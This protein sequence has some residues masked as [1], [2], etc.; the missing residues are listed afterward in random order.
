MTFKQLIDNRVKELRSK[1]AITLSPFWGEL[2]TQVK[3][4]YKSVGAALFVYNKALLDGV[5][6]TAVA[7]LLDIQAFEVYGMGGIVCLKST[8]DYA[9]SLGIIVIALTDKT[10]VTQS[11][12][13]AAARAWIAPIDPN[14]PEDSPLREGAFDCDAM[15][16]NPVALSGKNAGYVAVETERAGAGALMDC[17]DDFTRGISFA[18]A[19]DLDT[20]GVILRGSC[21]EIIS[22]V[23][24]KEGLI[25]LACPSGVDSLSQLK[26]LAAVCSL[27][28]APKEVKSP[29]TFIKFK[30]M[31]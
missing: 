26:E 5:K 9:K 4:K 30:E 18:E 28:V 7:V 24:S 22:A 2:P 17:Y 1:A 16:Y 19:I 12:I 3:E 23:K 15:T 25:S 20:C 8:I 6:E 14:L 10:G 27:V 29:D 21:D 11:A 13:K 31:L